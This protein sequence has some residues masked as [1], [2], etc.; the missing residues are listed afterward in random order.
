M[1]CMKLLAQRLMARGFDRQVSEFQIRVAILN[2][3][4]ANG[5][6]VTEAVG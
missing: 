6:P 1:H 5:A 2:R 4:T 3:F